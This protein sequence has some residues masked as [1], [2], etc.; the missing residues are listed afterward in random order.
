MK[1]KKVWE[2]DNSTIVHLYKDNI[3]NIL[4]FDL[5]EMIPWDFNVLTFEKIKCWCIPKELEGEVR[6]K[7]T[8]YIL[9]A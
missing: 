2:F 1:E 9:V 5:D 4:T 8:V 7:K 3:A 6:L